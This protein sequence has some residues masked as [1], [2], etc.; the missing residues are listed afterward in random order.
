MSWLLLD[1]GYCCN[2]YLWADV[3][4][5]KT[6]KCLHSYLNTHPKL[7]VPS[8]TSVTFPTIQLKDVLQ[9]WQKHSLRLKWNTSK[10]IVRHSR[11]PFLFLIQSLCIRAC[12]Y[13]EDMSSIAFSLGHLESIR[14]K[15][16]R[17]PVLQRPGWVAWLHTLTFSS[18]A[19]LI[20]GL[21]C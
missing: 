4:G 15:G 7:H 14:P 12:V 21:V 10:K 2:T 16:Y 5:N 11:W 6:R 8:K 3:Q 1:S 20:G 9:A 19:W 13:G 18:L 17:I